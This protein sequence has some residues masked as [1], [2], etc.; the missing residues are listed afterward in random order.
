MVNKD[1]YY[2]EA[3]VLESLRT[4]AL[5]LV[6]GAIRGVAMRQDKADVLRIKTVTCVGR[7]QAAACNDR[8][9]LSVTT[10]FRSIN[11]PLT[12]PNSSNK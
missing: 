10:R 5:S 8:I 3:I 7:G 12:R 4:I 6:V 2:S 9:E 1:D 11:A